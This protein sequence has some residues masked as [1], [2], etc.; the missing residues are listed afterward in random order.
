M[1]TTPAMLLNL[2]D[3]GV[4]PGPLWASM[5]N[6]AFFDIDSHDHSSN[7][8]V[9]VTPS[10]LNVDS[11]LPFNSNNAITLRSTAY[12]NQGAFLPNTDLRRIYV[13][14]GDLF[15]NNNLGVPVQI[16][17]GTTINIT[18]FGGIGGDYGQPGVQAAVTYSNITKTYLFVQSP[19]VTGGMAFGPI[20]IFENVMGA[21]SVTIRTPV[22]LGASYVLRLFP[23]LPATMNELVALDTIGN[24]TTGNPSASGG[25]IVSNKFLNT[26]D[27]FSLSTNA[28]TAPMGTSAAIAATTRPVIAWD[29][30]N[31][32]MVHVYPGTSN[33]IQFYPVGGYHS[34]AANFIPTG[35]LFCDGSA[36]SR[37]TYS[38][39]FNVITTAFGAGDGMTTFNL[40]DAR[41]RTLICAGQGQAN[42]LGDV[43][44]TLTTRTMFTALGRETHTLDT[45]QI[46]SHTHDKGTYAIGGGFSGQHSHTLNFLPTGVGGVPYV[47]STVGLTGTRL[48][49]YDTDALDGLPAGSGGGHTHSNAFFTGNSG[50]TGGGGTHNNMQPVLVVVVCIKY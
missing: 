45:T 28:L 25:G 12:D 40:P 33:L 19:G 2:P 9:Q 21:N 36:V 13:K 49:E 15:Y 50:A 5:L 18:G 48:T 3:V 46:P 22:A 27:T 16:T 7:K 31:K 44:P 26:N 34:F 10:G 4:I 14:G 23:S 41:G 24:L 20:S 42:Y 1:V 47:N 8:G 32:T 38:S 29:T 11:D 35:F 43:N 17:S 39:L 6:A 37:T 30:T